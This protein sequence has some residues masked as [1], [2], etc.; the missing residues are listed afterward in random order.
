MTEIEEAGGRDSSPRSSLVMQGTIAAALLAALLVALL[1]SGKSDNVSEEVRS[2][3]PLPR[4]GVSVAVSSSSLSAELAEAIKA[5]PDVTQAALGS[6]PVI[7]SEPSVAVKAVPEESSDVSL[8]ISDHASTP[9]AITPPP[10]LPIPPHQD[11]PARPHAAKATPI[12]SE[13]PPGV[14]GFALQLGV[15]TN[16]G[17]AEALQKKLK[18]A[19]IQAQLETRVQ[20][21]PFRTKEEALQTQERLRKIG[22]SAG[23]MVPLTK[24]PE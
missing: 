23:M 20:V 2:Q 15:F 19:G 12:E 10:S 14:T 8:K 7:S 24:K 6:T 16:T 13:N 21:G 3:T 18:R 9:R 11:V 5:A 1:F 17:N 4:V 22:M